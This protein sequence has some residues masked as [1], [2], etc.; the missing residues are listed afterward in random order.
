MTETD[1]L[2]APNPGS[3]RQTVTLLVISQVFAMSIWFSV[4]AIIPALAK[5]IGVDTA[6]LAI[7]PTAT[8]LGFVCGALLIDVTGLGDRVNS[9][10]LFAIS[11]FIVAAAN[12]TLLFI[13]ALSLWPRFFRGELS[14]WPWR[15][16]TR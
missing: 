5:D 8:Q 1:R 2:A 9:R 11:A 6:R 15:A 13:P 12:A 3:A 7:L 16:S 10:L 14:A 4:A